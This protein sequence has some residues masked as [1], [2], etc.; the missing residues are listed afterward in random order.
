MSR[1][2]TPDTLLRWHRRLIHRH[3]T[4]PHR[5][6][7]PPVDPHIAVLIAQMARETPAVDTSGSTVSCSAWGTGSARPRS[8]GS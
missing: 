3:W 5:G 2:V 6:G 8:G 7:R 4:Y 1:L